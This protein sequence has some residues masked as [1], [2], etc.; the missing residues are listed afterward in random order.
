M[1]LPYNFG[2]IDAFVVKVEKRA[3]GPEMFDSL[4]NRVDRKVDLLFS[5]P[6]AER[7]SE[8][9]VGQFITQAEP[10]EHVAGLQTRTGLSL[11][12]I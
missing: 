10:L 8:R 3:E 4:M 11:I 2:D 5:R 7:E 12:H 1:G 6:T 9:G